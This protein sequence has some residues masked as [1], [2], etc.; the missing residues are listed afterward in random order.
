MPV[1]TKDRKPKGR[2]ATGRRKGKNLNVWIDSALRAIMNELADE[3]RRP[4]RSEVELAL[5]Q[6]AASKGKWPPEPKS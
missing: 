2:P 1:M 4:L 3:S 5:E 6:Y